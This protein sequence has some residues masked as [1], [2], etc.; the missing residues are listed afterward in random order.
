MRNKFDL[1]M[2]RK[3]RVNLD[4]EQTREEFKEIQESRKLVNNTE[5]FETQKFS[6]NLHAEVI[7]YKETET[8][9]PTTKALFNENKIS[10]THIAV[11]TRFYSAQ[12]VLHKIQKDKEILLKHGEVKSVDKNEIK[13][14]TKLSRK[15]KAALLAKKY[16]HK[17]SFLRKIWRYKNLTE[18]QIEAIFSCVEKE[19]LKEQQEMALK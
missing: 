18:K 16:K 17:N 10:R 11:T 3:E 12:D 14:D 8:E 2:P 9:K 19:K 13:F 1:R 6:R 5:H 7:D 15:D 4:K